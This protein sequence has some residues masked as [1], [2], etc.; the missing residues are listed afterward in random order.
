VS[1]EGAGMNPPINLPASLESLPR[2]EHFPT[3][4]HRWNT[5]E[6]LL[7]FLISYFIYHPHSFTPKS[8]KS[9]FF[10]LLRA[11]QFAFEFSLLSKL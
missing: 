9:D 8:K 5:N 7:F 1:D 10:F 4:R 6:V 11:R 2:A 3:Q